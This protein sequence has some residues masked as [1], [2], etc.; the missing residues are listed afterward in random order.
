MPNTLQ[1]TLANDVK[2][3]VERVLTL[4]LKSLYRILLHLKRKKAQAFWI[5][6]SHRPRLF[7]HLLIEN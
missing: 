6:F 7:R 3:G 2:T 4:V 5:V 1:L